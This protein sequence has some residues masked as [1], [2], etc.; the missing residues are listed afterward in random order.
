MEISPMQFYVLSSNK[1]AAYYKHVTY[2]I[3]V[4]YSFYFKK[5][6][7]RMGSRTYGRYEY[8]SGS[9]LFYKEELEEKC[10]DV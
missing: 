5:Y 9:I 3:L 7:V 4:K 1:T 10:S 6:E 8:D 2:L